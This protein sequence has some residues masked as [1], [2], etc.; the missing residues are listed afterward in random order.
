MQDWQLHPMLVSEKYV[1]LKERLAY[2]QVKHKDL[3]IEVSLLTMKLS[4]GQRYL[5]DLVAFAASG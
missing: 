4:S 1:S 2:S 5:V 3:H